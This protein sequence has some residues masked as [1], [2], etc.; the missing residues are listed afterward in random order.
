MLQM[1]AA[2]G[3]VAAMQRSERRTAQQPA[4]RWESYATVMTGLPLWQLPKEHI[5]YFSNPA[6]AGVIAAVLAS[7]G[8]GRQVDPKVSSP[9]DRARWHHMLRQYWWW[10]LPLTLAATL[11][12]IWFYQWLVSLA[13]PG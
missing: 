5:T 10:G 9:A 11:L 6:V 7:A 3:M 4:A 2:A 13:V 1:S 12:V 8:S